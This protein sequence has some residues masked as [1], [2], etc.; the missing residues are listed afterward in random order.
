MSCDEDVAANGLA[1]ADPCGD[2]VFVGLGLGCTWEILGVRLN[3]GHEAAAGKSW[4]DDESV[5][6]LREGF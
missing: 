5:G 6:I 1:D 4:G 2:H 3:F